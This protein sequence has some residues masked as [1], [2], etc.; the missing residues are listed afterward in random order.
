MKTKKKKLRLALLVDSL[1]IPGWVERMITLIAE[2]GYASFVLV[3]KNERGNASKGDWRSRF[4]YATYLLHRKLDRV[5]GGASSSAFSP[6]SL[7][8]SL[9][10]AELLCVSPLQGKYTDTI[11]E[12]AC[13]EIQGYDIDIA[14]RLGFRIL[15]GDI[16]RTAR[17]G[18]WSYHHGDERL[19][20]GGPPGFW[21]VIEGWPVTGV[22]LQILSSELDGGKV[23]ARTHCT[24]DPTFVS[25]NKE[26]VYWNSAPLLPRMIEH[27]YHAGEKDFFEEL[28]KPNSEL[29]FYSRRLYRTPSNGEMLASFFPYIQRLV[30]NRLYSLT[31]DEKWVLFYRHDPG[32]KL[33]TSLR[34]Y[35]ML[36]PPEGHE[37]AD[38]FVTRLDYVYYVFFEDLNRERGKA[39]ISCLRFTPDEGWSDSFEVLKQDYHLSYPFVFCFGGEH[40]MI[41]ESAENGTIE[42]YRALDFPASWQLQRVLMTNVKAR[43]T[44][45]V[46]KDG[47]WWMFTCLQESPE[48]ST[49]QEMFIFYTDDLLAGAWTPHRMNPVVSDVQ[50]ARPAGAC[51]EHE[52][53]FYRPS[54]NCGA[55][56]GYSVKL[57]RVK[58]L[59]KTHYKEECTEEIEPLWS[60]DIKRVHTFNSCDGLT[61]VD[62]LLSV[63]KF[64]RG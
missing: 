24:T 21:E 7:D 25:R 56:Y 44:T 36:Q 12:E 62:G 49:W 41:P 8:S 9:A 42:L 48:M 3:V 45:L 23:L 59:S 14:I 46:F 6:K 16:L 35:Q 37:W 63:P 32:G 50:S 47:L 18:I 28:D 53:H 40:Y 4:R 31:R 30:S 51:F 27:L 61:L 64:G 19:N 57:N 29:R 26:R 43:D 1:T 52:G 2:G 11:P 22:T 55:R 54:Q 10:R 15:K 34:Q 33:S 60:P 13:R 17:Y 39:H 5:L 38:P 58:T 20:R